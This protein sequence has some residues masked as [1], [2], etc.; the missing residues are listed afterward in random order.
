MAEK[1]P[2]RLNNALMLFFRVFLIAVFLSAFIPYIN[3]ARPSGRISANASLF[4]SATSYSIIKENLVRA[5]NSGW[6][7]ESSVIITYAGAVMCGLAI[8]LVVAA[9]CMS[10]GNTR[11][12]RL[13]LMFSCIA[14][15]IGIIGS[16]V[17]FYA[18]NLFYATSNPEHLQ[19]MLPMGILVFYGI[20]AAQ[21][22]LAGVLLYVLPRPAK[23]EPYEIAPKYRLFLMIFPFLIL[24]TLFSYLPLWGWRYAFFDPKPGYALDGFV[25]L[26]YFV[27][28][29][30]NP[31]QRADILRVLKNTFTMSGIGLATSWLPIVFAVFLSEIR[32]N[33]FKRSVQT[34]T[35]IPNFISWALVYSIAFALFSTEGFYN[36]LLSVLGFID[37]GQGEA[38]LNSYGFMWVKMWLWGTWKGLGW[39][40]IIY[41][42]AIS[43]IDQQLYEAAT[44]DG[45][46]RFRRIW[47][48]TVPGLL[49]TFF[50]LLLLAIAN[51]LSNGMEQYFV[52]QTELNK[53]GVE[54]LDLY[55]YNL[56]LANNTAATIPLATAVGMLKSI[57][58]VTLLFMANKV[59]KLL[60]GESII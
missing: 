51:I 7:N 33:K 3:P 11:M 35:T 38:H 32:F 22:L 44:V 40:A 55:V 34:I 37:K 8:L 19:P 26:K 1:K 60:R 36:W 52:F 42:A 56:G 28:L 2:S 14:S 50:V 18:C 4:T 13:C 27:R 58:S 21:L 57:L 49:P 41:I 31:A 45:A 12:R 15:I 23:G 6:I 25:G 10:I 59:S 17:L 30:S 43:G 20:F 53:P 9:F 29:F 24:V 48:I 5:L 47:H 46:G 16:S 54:V 39:S